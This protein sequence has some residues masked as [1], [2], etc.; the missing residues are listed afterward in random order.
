MGAQTVTLARSSPDAMITSIDVSETSLL[1]ARRKVT[2]E[3]LTNVLFELGDI[4]HLPYGPDSFDHI[5]VCFVLEHL[6]NPA[7][8]LLALKSHS[9]PGG[10][11]TV[12]E[13]TTVLGL[14]SS[15]Q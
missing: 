12:I 6:A 8:A 5:F 2:A 4:F 9:A 15:R 13:G 11:I 3:G 7:A 10:T 14:F 1:E